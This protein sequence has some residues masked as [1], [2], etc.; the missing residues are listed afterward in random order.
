LAERQGRSLAVESL[1]GRDFQY[2]AA[3]VFAVLGRLDDAFR[4]LAHAADQR[5]ERLALVVQD[6]WL[7]SLHSDPRFGALLRRMGLRA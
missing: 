6:P 4:L 5:D 1:A 2:E 7:A 3:R